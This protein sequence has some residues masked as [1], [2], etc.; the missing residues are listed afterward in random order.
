MKQRAVIIRPLAAGALGWRSRLGELLAGAA[1]P[2]VRAA[3]AVS[4]ST[5]PEP[6]AT[7]LLTPHGRSGRPHPAGTH[8]SS[9][10]GCVLPRGPGGER[11]GMA[12]QRGSTEHAG[13]HPHFAR[14]DAYASVARL[15]TAFAQPVASHLFC[16]QVSTKSA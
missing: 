5:A 6:A 9:W 15:A 7:A 10:R 2:T 12:S 16:L 8:R 3:L 13:F 4:R 14:G 1:A 11:M